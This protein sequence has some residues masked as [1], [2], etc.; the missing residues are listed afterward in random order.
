MIHVRQIEAS[1]HCH[2]TEDCSK[3]I[4]ALKNVFPTDVSL[5][6]DISREVVRGYY[7]NPIE[8]YR[9]R[10]EG[11]HCTK[12][13]HNVI[14]RLS[15]DDR[16]VLI[17]TLNIRFDKKT[18]KLYLRLNK[19]SAFNNRLELMDSDDVIKIVFSLKGNV[20]L[21]EL[22]DFINSLDSV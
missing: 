5:N 8:L 17:M 4:Q 21:K 10:L 12:V 3:V 20:N 9:V 15:P 6:M 14:G 13:L 16:R 18:K 11:E 1:T 22:E 2:A 19:Q 7:G